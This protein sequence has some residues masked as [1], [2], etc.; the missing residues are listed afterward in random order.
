MR[1]SLVSLIVGSAIILLGVNAH[2]ITLSFAPASTSVSIGDPVTVL[3]NVSGLGDKAAP[4]LGVFDVNVT[5][6]PALLAFVDATFGDPMLGDQLDLGKFGSP[7]SATVSPANTLNLSET[8][9]DSV[10]DLDTMQAGSFTLATL[11][12]NAIGLGV[13][14]LGLSIN[15]LGDANGDTLA[16]T[17]NVGTVTVTATPEPTTGLLFVTGLMVL[18]YGWHRKQRLTTCS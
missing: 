5:F 10:S 17:A 8:S 7:T 6:D 3:L 14:P 4:S 9:F 13:S 2:A 12:F 11:A 1:R 18:G 15:T 16:A